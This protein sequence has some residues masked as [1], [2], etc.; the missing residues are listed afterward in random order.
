MGPVKSPMLHSDTNG[1][2]IW[3]YW[4]GLAPTC[5]ETLTGTP[6]DAL[7]QSYLAYCPSMTYN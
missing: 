6:L 4:C 5:P 3:S 7:T 1:Y 2:P